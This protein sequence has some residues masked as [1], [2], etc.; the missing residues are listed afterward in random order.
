MK[1]ERLLG[2][3]CILASTDKITIQELA[4]RFEVSRRT[5]FRDLDTLNCAGI[6]IVSYPGVGGGVAV[7][8]GY[9]VER[10][11]LSTGDT[12]K[13][14]MA[15][16]AL[17]SIEGD[18]AITNLIAKLVPEKTEAVFS[19]S[20]YVIDLSSWFGDS[21]VH[22]KISALHRAIRERRCILLEYIS[23][24]YRSIR[25]VEPHKLVF[26][27][28]YWYIYAF[29]RKRNA[30][31]LFKINRIVSYEILEEHFQLRPIAAIEFD[32]SYS[33]ELF[34][35]KSQADLFDVVLEYNTSDEFDLT[36]KIDA[37]FFH[38][39]IEGQTACGQ[40]R[41]QVSNLEWTADLVLGLQD[42]VR[43]ISPPALQ[44]EIKCRLDKINFCY[45]KKGDI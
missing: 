5:I 3:L 17:K 18:T 1:L 15:L 21:I 16:S 19:Q 29:C 2:L 30:F 37:A 36:N 35:P 6:P 8:E 31:R 45:N 25:T 41:F 13:V 32:N 43:V 9:K 12:E 27:Q 20:D 33:T 39:S 44:K 38:R 42:K 26:K 7:V 4:D 23:K 22:K 34:S 40:I 24:D 10:N 28:S 14:F 11:V